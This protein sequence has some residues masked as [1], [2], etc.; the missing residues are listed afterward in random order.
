MDSNHRPHAYQKR[1]VVSRHLRPIAPQG[2]PSVHKTSVFLTAKLRNRKPVFK[3]LSEGDF[4]RVFLTVQFRPLGYEPTRV[5]SRLSCSI[6]YVLLVAWS[7]LLFGLFSGRNLDRGTT[8]AP[9]I[10]LWCRWG[11]GSDRLC[12]LSVISDSTS[13]HK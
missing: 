11:P 9:T 5:L 12:P 13:C 1:Q 6:T 8:L 7:F 4:G 2:G 3:G 10:L